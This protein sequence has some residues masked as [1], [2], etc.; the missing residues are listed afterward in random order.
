MSTRRGIGASPGVATGPVARFGARPVLPT[1]A[2]G[3]G[4]DEPG[5]AAAALE[6]VAAELDRR[7]ERTGSDIL[8]ATAMIARDPGLADRIADL[9]RTQPAAWAVDSAI[10]EYRALL[11]CGY[12]AER[13]TDLDDIRDRAVAWLLDRPVPG[14]PSPGHPYVLVA[15]DLAPADT[16]LL[17]PA[18]VLAIV[19]ERGGPTSHTA[20]LAKALGIPAVVGCAGSFVDGQVVQVDGDAGVV[21]TDPVPVTART[22]LDIGPGRTADGHRVELLANIGGPDPVPG[23]EGVGLVRTEFLFLGRSRPPTVREQQAAYRE[24][25]APLVGRKVVVRTLDAGSDKPIPYAATGS[26]LGIRGFRIAR[27]RPDLLRDQ[28][29]ALARAA[30]DTGATPWVM[31]PMITT[32]TEAAAF[33]TAARE[34]GLS[35]AGAMIEVPAAALR[36]GDI[37]AEVDFLSI[38]SND[39]AQYTF[40]AD[41]QLTDLAD[42]LDPW[43]PALLDL[44][45]HVATIPKPVSVCGEAAADPLLALVFAGMGIGALSMAPVSLPAVRT[46]L[47]AHTLPQCRELAAAVRRATT[48]AE[49]RATARRLAEEAGQLRG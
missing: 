39:L 46:A 24:V 27:A 38:G 42:L 20:I 32:A 26:A 22:L 49:A 2:P 17:D 13:T 47:A 29:E 43:Q 45:A 28:L 15:P 21:R 4:P 1:T 12:L 37:A 18:Q 41:R 23:V 10:G 6:H 16:A 25:L 48:P 31:A 44:I 3:L 30:A 5:R 8:A 36:A 33:A 35:T 9:A 7:A 11:A 40:A 19:T 34:H 14:P